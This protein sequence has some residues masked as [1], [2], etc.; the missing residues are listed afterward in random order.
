MGINGLY[1]G[2]LGLSIALMP[3]H[4]NHSLRMLGSLEKIK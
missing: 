2:Q 4:P 1:L 3:N